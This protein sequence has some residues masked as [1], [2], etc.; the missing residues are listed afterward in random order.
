MLPP[1]GYSIDRALAF[2]NDL[3]T[4]IR[5]YWD[6]DPDDPQSKHLEYPIIGDY[7]FVARSAQLFMGLRSVDQRRAGELVRLIDNVTQ[8]VPGAITRASQRSLFSRELGVGR[9]IDIEITGP[10]LNELV[11]VGQQIFRKVPEIIRLTESVSEQDLKP[12]DIVISRDAQRGTAERV[13]E[14]ARAFPVPSLELNSPELHV[15][16]KTK[17]ASD[18][19]VSTEELGYTVNALVDGA[20]ASDYYLGGRKIDLTIVGNQRYAVRTQD[21][22]S[23]AVATPT[24]DLTRLDGLADIQFAG[25]PEQIRRRERQRAITI[26]VTPPVKNAPGNRHQLDRPANHTTGIRVGRDSV[27]LPD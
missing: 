18:M 25:G 22:G 6:V 2:G 9:T 21:L 26:S 7:F 19:G 8:D 5:P 3:E 17:Q 10:D 1:P 24:G 11:K 20:Y 23:L 16:R 15:V 14:A 27:E 4:A 12:T 13:K